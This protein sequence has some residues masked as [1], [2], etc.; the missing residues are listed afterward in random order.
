MDRSILQCWQPLSGTGD[1]MYKALFKM[2]KKDS[3]MAVF[4]ISVCL[5]LVQGVLKP[6]CA[7]V[8]PG[9]GMRNTVYR[10]LPQEALLSRCEVRTG[11][12]VLKT[13][14]S[15]DHAAAGERGMRLQEPSG[16]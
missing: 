3:K 12:S 11:G 13:E 10:S 9:E 7:F 1:K 14:T 6:G 15:G 4:I 16:K 2:S 5:S 8:S